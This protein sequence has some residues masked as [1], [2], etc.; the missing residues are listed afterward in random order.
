[1]ES[2]DHAAAGQ[3]IDSKMVAFIFEINKGRSLEDKKCVVVRRSMYVMDWICIRC[4]SFGGDESPMTYPSHCDGGYIAR[5]ILRVVA[6]AFQA[7]L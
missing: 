5:I 1:M 2:E 6:L 7:R 3:A 4:R